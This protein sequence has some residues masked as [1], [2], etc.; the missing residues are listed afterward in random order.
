MRAIMAT[1]TDPHRLELE[2]IDDLTTLGDQIV[3]EDFSRELYRTLTNMRCSKRGWPGHISL[4]WQRVDEIINALRESHGGEPMTL[5]QSGGEGQ[6]CRH[7]QEALER[8]GWSCAPLDTSAHDDAHVTSPREAPPPDT[9]E[10]LAPVDPETAH[11]EERA[12]EEA[13]RE[14]RRRNLG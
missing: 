11:W 13:E 7:A 9:G 1:T 6:P 5:A 14:R 12:H 3:D 2:L 4:S 8:L 10:R